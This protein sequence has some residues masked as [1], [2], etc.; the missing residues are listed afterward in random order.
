MD[1]YRVKIRRNEATYLWGGAG[2]KANSQRILAVPVM[3]TIHV[4]DLGEEVE[5][6]YKQAQ[7]NQE[8]SFG[9][10]KPG[11]SYTV[12]LDKLTAIW[13]KSTHDSYVDCQ[14][15]VPSVKLP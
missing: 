8:D 13:A 12:S 11:E 2:I 10:L 3:L 6:G 9:K 4:D 5:F 7:P 1:R 15:T 14:L